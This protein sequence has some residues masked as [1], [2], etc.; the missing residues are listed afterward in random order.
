MVTKRMRLAAAA[1]AAVTALAPTRAIADDGPGSGHS[2]NVDLVELVPDDDSDAGE[3]GGD[4]DA[5]ACTG[6]SGPYQREV[7]KY[8]KLPVDGSQ[9]AADCEAIRAFQ[10][11]YG[12]TPDTGYAGPVTWG[13]MRL[14]QAQ[15]N[16]NAA[17]KCPVRSGQRVVCVDL[18]RQLLWVQSGKKVTY[19]PVSIRTGRRGY[20]TRI[21]W[22]EVYERKRDQVS[23]IYGTKMPFSQFFDGG[24]ALH[25]ISSGSVYGPPG[26]YGC[27]NLSYSDAQSLWGVLKLKDRVYVWGRK[28]GT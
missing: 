17:G 4:A 26:S 3:P 23:E 18:N 11:E 10:S 25:A 22:H 14:E 13:W 27:V 28:P 16:P 20:E 6:Q 21:G 15:G 9:S 5:G 19:G 1:L 12:I 2:V 24:E 7:E 8:L